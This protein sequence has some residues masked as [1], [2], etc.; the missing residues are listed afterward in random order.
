MG[1]LI[2][3]INTRFGDLIVLERD[4]TK[5]GVYWLCKCV[6]NNIVSVRSDCLRK[7]NYQN[8]G[9][10]RQLIN[11]GDKFGLYT[12]IKKGKLGKRHVQFWIC[13]C[14]CGNIS[15][16]RTSALLNGSSKSCGCLITKFNRYKNPY[17]IGDIR[18]YFWESI[19]RMAKERNIKFEL[20]PQDIWQQWN[21]Q[22]GICALSNIKLTLPQKAREKN[23]ATASL[24]RINSNDYYHKNNIQWIHKDINIMKN[25]FDM[26][27]FINICQQIASTQNKKV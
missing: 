22:K 25:K 9:C 4:Y 2:D 8:C 6:C 10:K 16:V 27:Y 5:T 7:R 26:Q 18:P 13:Q 23:K 17:T 3:L 20:T 19:K 12:V 21:T 11:I 24:D 15:E 14:E 1:K